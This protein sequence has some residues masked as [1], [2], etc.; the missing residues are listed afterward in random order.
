MTE[1]K[2]LY[3][4]RHDRIIAGVC[5]GLGE[6]FGLDPVLF[7]ISFLLLTFVGGSGILLY[8]I[9][10]FIVPL[11]SG[12]TAMPNGGEKVEEFAKEVGERAK[13]LA[14]EFVGGK[15]ESENHKK[16][17]GASGRNIFGLFLV[18]AGLL[19]FL[20]ALLPGEL[21][22]WS[23]VWPALIFFLGISILLRSGQ[24]KS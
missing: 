21:F 9:L 18:S 12:D 16:E 5:G 22:Q 13:N 11:H 24:K 7:R 14:H 10:V 19:I 6:Y 8:V 17:K 2:K 4:S 20:N 3:R 15:S 1:T 23:L